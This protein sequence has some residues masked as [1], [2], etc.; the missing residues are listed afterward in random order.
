MISKETAQQQ[1]KWYKKNE[2][3]ILI[4]LAGIFGVFGE[5]AIASLT[6]LFALH[7]RLNTPG[8]S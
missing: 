8:E 1:T 5:Y 4:A 2:H 6:A 3:Y 7:S